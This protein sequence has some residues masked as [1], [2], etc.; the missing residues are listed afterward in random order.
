[1]YAKISHFTITE[2]VITRPLL[3][4]FNQALGD[5]FSVILN[6]SGFLDWIAFISRT[7]VDRLPAA[8]AAVPECP[9]LRVTNADFAECNGDYLYSY[10]LRVSWAPDR[11]VY[12]HTDR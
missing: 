9:Q 7:T 6:Y 8:G 12:V 10:S 5:N 2:K 1:M 3:E 11:P 4:A